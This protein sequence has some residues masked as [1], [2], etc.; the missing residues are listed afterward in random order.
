ME[1]DQSEESVQLDTSAL[2]DLPG[3]YTKHASYRVKRKPVSALDE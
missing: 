1:I 3:G 2:L